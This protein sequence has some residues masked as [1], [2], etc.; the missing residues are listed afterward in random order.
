MQSQVGRELMDQGRVRQRD[1][2][3]HERDFPHPSSVAPDVFRIFHFFQ[4]AE[5]MEIVQAEKSKD[6]AEAGTHFPTKHQQGERGAQQEEP[7]PKRVP[8]IK[9]A[10]GQEGRHR[11]KKPNEFPA[12]GNLFLSD[13]AY[14]R[15]VLIA[16][17]W[18]GFKRVNKDVYK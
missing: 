17:V 14:T 8:P 1:R 4:F 12:D 10:D 7:D 3:R 6:D 13:V 15:F 9:A 2:H 18:H 16:T 11:Q 5:V